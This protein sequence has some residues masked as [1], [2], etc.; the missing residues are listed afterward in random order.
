MITNLDQLKDLVA[1]MKSHGV[2]E[3]NVNG[4]AVIFGLHSNNAADALLETSPS[5]QLQNIKTTLQ[6]LK[7]EAD[8]DEMWSV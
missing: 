4:V 6:A 8:A 3:F 1:F 2:Q 7:N 5:E